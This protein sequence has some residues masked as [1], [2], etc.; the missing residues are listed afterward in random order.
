M[1]HTRV[2]ASELVGLGMIRGGM[3]KQKK[4]SCESSFPTVE[5][6]TEYMDRWKDLECHKV[7]SALM[8]FVPSSTVLS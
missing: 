4:G 1:R 7:P 3:E 5:L 2:R 8:P 6:R